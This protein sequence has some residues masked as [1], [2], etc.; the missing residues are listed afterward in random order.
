MV[1][2]D[3]Y[4]HYL[5]EALRFSQAFG[6]KIGRKA[7]GKTCMYTENGK[8]IV[9]D[10]KKG[11]LNFPQVYK[12]DDIWNAC[13]DMIKRVTHGEE[14]FKRT[15][16][17][18][19]SAANWAERMHE[20]M[21]PKAFKFIPIDENYKEFLLKYIPSVDL[22]EEI[23][24]NGHRFSDFEKAAIVWNSR[25]TLFEKH[26]DLQKIADAT[27]DVELRE[28]IR[29]RIA[30]DKDVLQAFED[31]SDG[32][33]YIVD[34]HEFV[35]EE[36]IYGYF[37]NSKL[38][39]EEGCESGFD[40]CISKHQLLD[41]GDERVKGR[42]LFSPLVREDE[43]F[44]EMPFSNG[45]IAAVEYDVNGD[46]LSYYSYELP[47]ERAIK[48]ET[49]SNKR[50]ENGYV[51]FPGTFK[52]DEKV[53]VVGRGKDDGI[54]GWV[55]WL[56]E[57]KMTK[58]KDLFDYSDTS[59]TVDYWDSNSLIWEHD[60]II[61]I[62]LERVAEEELC[63]SF[64]EDHRVIIGHDRGAAVWFQAVEVFVTG[65]IISKNVTG[66]GKEVSVDREFFNRVLRPLFIE[67]FD[68][69]MTENSLRYT[70]A[71]SEEGRYLTGFE[72]DCL[73]YNFYT[74]TQIVSVIDR[75]EG[76]IRDRAKRIENSIGGKD[77]TQM[78]TF[79][80]YIKRIMEDNP[81]YRLI[82]LMS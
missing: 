23:I 19:A 44:G 47:K 80:E 29:E 78:L 62:Y 27:E 77:A 82:A 3:I 50:F 9:A 64:D 60:H 45:I 5:K 34:S 36:N 24:K 16:D 12:Q 18:W 69:S 6:Y 56:S 66:I 54:I 21:A 75:I 1:S 76:L 81:D 70:Y 35:S 51:V 79:V 20:D 39:Y 37:K 73:E 22:R 71:F 38:A 11:M 8:W 58:A 43:Q 41:E 42:V 10:V 61:P 46:I 72:E 65:R 32:V 4:I 13:E 2:T 74:Y 33:V 49:L 57:E 48:V 59:L 63:N 55:S 7:N 53:R 17:Y 40:F 26:K 15:W 14:D 68:P 31:N 67:T 30:Y 25:I 52:E 28:Q